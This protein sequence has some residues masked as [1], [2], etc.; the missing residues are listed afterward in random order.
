[1]D[2]EVLKQVRKSMRRLQQAIAAEN[3]Q[4][5][6]WLLGSTA[7]V[8]YKYNGKTASEL[9]FQTGNV[10]VMDKVFRTGCDLNKIIDDEGNTFLTKAICDGS[11]DDVLTSLLHNGA[12][13]DLPN[14]SDLTPLHLAASFG[15][16][17]AIKILVQRA[18]YLNRCDSSGQTALFKCSSKG[19]HEIVK[20]LI[21]TGADIEWTDNERRTP[22]FAA[23]ETNHFNIVKILIEA[24]IFIKIY[25]CYELW[26]FWHPC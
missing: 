22:L 20:L 21:E 26:T 8:D 6:E 2:R 14:N 12:D 23:V 17:S 16:L 13:P 11:S 4:D 15:R 19:H 3:V 1:M 5:L 24:G 18:S 7:D 25:I 10:N 9:A